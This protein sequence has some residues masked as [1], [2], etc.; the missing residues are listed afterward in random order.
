[1]AFELRLYALK[2]LLSFQ[3]NRTKN[4]SVYVNYSLECT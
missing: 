1:M 2:I 3:L 4:I